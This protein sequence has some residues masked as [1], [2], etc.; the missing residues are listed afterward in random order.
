MHKTKIL[1]S[2]GGTGGHIFPA[3]AIANALKAKLT[4]VEFLFVGAKGKME[5]QKIPAAGY[6]IKGIWISGLQRRL[7]LKNLLFPFKLIISY[8]Q[9]SNIIRKF[10]PDVVIGTGGYASGPAIQAAL[11]KKIP[12]LIQ[13][14][15]SFPGITNRLL[16][17]KV[18]KICVS[19]EGMERY[20]PK[21][22]IVLSGNPVRSDIVKGPE[23]KETALKTF[24]LH[25]NKLVLL[26]FGGSQGS[27]AINEA[28]G[29]N[30]QKLATLNIQILWQTGKTYFPVAKENIKAFA[31]Q[32]WQ[33]M[34]FINRMDLAYAAADIVLCRAGAITIS[35]LCATGKAAILVPLPAA[36]ED[37]QTKNALKLTEKQA[38]ILLKNDEAK[39]KLIDVLHPLVLNEANRLSL[40]KNIKT[41]AKPDAAEIIA[42]EVIRLINKKYGTG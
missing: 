24:K 30:L 29:A 40:G 17:K 23:H 3:L 35:E 26:I 6:P 7:S 42:D 22:K 31:D 19:F 13:E 39:D 27:L 5:M 20:F 32:K 34:E 8:F 25:K 10:K 16:A 2:G 41:M 14:Q 9:A 36:A 38:G 12:G 1:I 11:R 37:H 21:H 33:C 18:D 28:V 15:N 4:H